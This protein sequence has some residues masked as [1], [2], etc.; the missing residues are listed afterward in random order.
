MKRLFK[1]GLS[2][3]I[4]AVFFMCLFYACARIGTPQGG[5]YDYTPPR[6]VSSVPEPNAVNYHGQKI[7]IVFDEL[8]TVEKPMEK[9]IITP[10]Q[11]KIPV[12]KSN[13]KK[14]TV[15]LKDSLLP[16][17][18]YTFDFTDA[19]QD[20]NEQN[21]LENFTFAFSTGESVDSLIIG[22]ILLNA[23]NLEPMPNIMIGL[24]TDLDDTAFTT[25][26]FVRTTKT[27]DRGQF[28]VRN[29]AHGSYRVFALNEVN[30]DYL[31]DQPGEDIAF[32]DSVFVPG[33][34][35]AVRQDTVWKDSLTIDTIR[36]IHYNRFIP[37]DI[38]LFLFKEEF[39]RQYLSKYER[40]AYS[41]N[42]TF[43]SARDL[44]PKITL[45][46]KEYPKEAW[47]IPEISDDG[48][49]RIYWMKDSLLYRADTLQ[50]EVDYLKS[51]TIN[52]L[53]QA[54]DTIYFALKKQPSAKKD[55][56]EEVKIN[57]LEAAIS[58]QGTADVFDTLKIVFSEPL[59]NPDLSQ[60]KIEQ[61][62]DTLWEP[63]ELEWV[64]DHL[65]PRMYFIKQ[66]WPYGGEYKITIDSAAMFSIYD[67]WNDQTEA[68]FRFHQNSDYGH[69]FIALTGMESKGFGEL[70]DHSDRVVRSSDIIDGELIFTNLKPGKYFLRYM[71]DING[72]KKWDT[73]NYAEKRLPEPV[74]Y[75]PSFFDIRQNFEIEQ[76][77]NVKETPVEKQ[78]PL[79]I[80]KN[81][82]I[83]KQKRRIEDQRTNTD[84]GNSNQNTT[85]SASPF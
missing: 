52:Q 67:K 32:I 66:K 16:N 69:L 83:E 38:Q 12:I 85:R 73:G 23:E 61:K 46:N 17:T 27:N 54:K 82:P 74:Y 58:L 59:R 28:W 36:E 65:N 7:E 30:R 31:F 64:P 39:D 33:F 2:I 81:K 40:T 5:A 13:G 62:I 35:P 19:I 51:D 22:G 80:T 29:V 45:L 76:S 48:K 3:T 60:I 1:N 15:E 6:Y 24:H 44:D 34:L 21:K 37:D 77:W 25:L 42:F 56:K 14:I 53:V 18:T 63:K 4:F 11:K 20:N 57:F 84:R 49:T 41:L 79:E 70:L 10:P 71:E 55:K 68:Q 43:N 47:A 26:P 50:V 9:V 8:V 72:N 78:K 75:Y